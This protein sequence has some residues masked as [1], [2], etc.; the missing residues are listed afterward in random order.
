VVYS[1]I[2]EGK[3]CH[4]LSY[5]RRHYDLTP[6]Y[7]RFFKVADDKDIIYKL[8]EVGEVFFI[9]KPLYYYRISTRGASRGLEGLNKARDEK[10]IAARNAIARREKSGV[11][12]IPAK[13]FTR[14]LSEHYLL[15]AEGYILM[16]K[17]LGRPF[18]ACML[19][20][21]THHPFLNF[22]RKVKAALLLSRLKRMATSL[23]VHHNSQ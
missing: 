2:L 11:K 21:F 7:D 23:L 5:K 12:Q 20:S 19:K 3:V 1:D 17:P 6:G 10:L 8:E 22:K 9:D 16:D 14:L 18:V 13:A 15:Q 4:L